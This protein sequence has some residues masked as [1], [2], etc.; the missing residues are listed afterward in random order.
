MQIARKITIET[1]FALAVVGPTV[2]IKVVFS[3]YRH[4]LPDHH[5]LPLTAYRAVREVASVVE[6]VSASHLETSR[7]SPLTLV[8]ALTCVLAPVSADFN[9]GKCDEWSEQSTEKHLE[10]HKDSVRGLCLWSETVN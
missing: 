2:G 3:L 6:V 5:I 7:N 1:R 10:K 8:A 4:G 9:S